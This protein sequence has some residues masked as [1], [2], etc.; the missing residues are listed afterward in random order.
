M[1][2]QTE[3]ACLLESGALYSI[4]LLLRPEVGD[5]VFAGFKDGAFS[6]YF[7]DA[8]IIHFDLEGRWQRAFIESVH[9][10]KALDTTVQAINRVREGPNLV[11]KRRTLAFAEASDLDAFIRGLVLD[12][13][14]E[15]DAGRLEPLPPPGHSKSRP[16]S[17]DE[18]RDF[19]ERIAAW[20]AAAWFAHRERYQ[21]TYG[22]LPVLPPD[23]PGAVILQATRDRCARTASEFDH[24]A[25]AVAALIGR[26]VEQCKSVFLADADVLRRPEDELAAFLEI[27]ARVFQ[28]RSDAPSSVS[29][30]TLD[31]VHAFLDDPAPPLLPARRDWRRLRALGLK[32]VSLGVES[33]DASVRR[34][35]GKNWTDNDLRAVVSALKQAGLGVGL[36]VAVGAGGAENASRHFEQTAALVNSLD[37]GPGDLVSLLDAGDLS[38]LAPSQPVDRPDVTPLSGE[39]RS[40]QLDALKSGLAPTRTVRG[41]K[42]APFWPEKQGF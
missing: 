24:H 31:G 17:P 39:A 7:G 9:H 27:I 16:L 40:I 4:R 36:I 29:R 35:F 26:R 13:A 18:L 33:G 12:L 38:A 41:A 1:A 21:A 19:L 6:L 20:D 15:V 14:R 30:R 34:Q 23:C 42:V 2:Q 11:L 37:L 22:P 3:A 32:R 5:P 8:P 25:R 10:L 28:I